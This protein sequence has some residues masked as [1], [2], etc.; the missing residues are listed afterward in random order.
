MTCSDFIVTSGRNDSSKSHYNVVLEFSQH[1]ATFT[2]GSYQLPDDTWPWKQDGK[3]RKNCSFLKHRNNVGF[4]KMQEY[5]RP[6]KR[7]RCREFCL[8]R[9]KSFTMRWQILYT[10][11]Y[12]TMTYART[13]HEIH[14]THDVTM[15]IK[16]FNGCDSVFLQKLFL[17]FCNVLSLHVVSI[18]RLSVLGEGP[19]HVS[20][21]EA[22]TFP[23]IKRFFL[24]VFSWL[25]LRV[26]ERGCCI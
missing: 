12:N 20:L 2:Y 3:I 15:L 7:G 23:P 5:S 25:L 19:S 10:S 22:S 18:A 1:F 8:F 14:W 11:S 26:K 16:P 24:V 21:S 17:S 6:Y 9:R 13:L 4:W